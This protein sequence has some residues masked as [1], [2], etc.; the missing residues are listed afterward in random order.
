[1]FHDVVVE[2]AP[3]VEDFAAALDAL[4]AGLAGI[5]EDTGLVHA[6][7][8]AEAGDGAEL[9]IL[10]VEVAAEDV[11]VVL[12]DE[13]LASLMF[14]GNL[15]LADGVIDVL[16][17]DVVFVH[18]FLDGVPVLG[19]GLAGVEAF[20]QFLR[21]EVDAAVEVIDREAFLLGAFAD[22]VGS[23]AEDAGC[24]FRGDVFLLL[25]QG[26]GVAGVQRGEAVERISEFPDVDAD[27]PG[28]ELDGVDGTFLDALVD[29]GAR[30]VEEGRS[31]R[32]GEVVLGEEDVPRAVLDYGGFV[33][34][35]SRGTMTLMKVVVAEVGAEM[36]CGVGRLEWLPAV[37]TDIRAPFHCTFLNF[38]CG[39]GP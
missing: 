39:W 9:D 25:G 13:Q 29:G 23:E 18:D 34:R 4:H 33:R 19:T 32:D 3:D 30:D 12:G 28:A 7:F 14:L 15:L 27:G 20:L 22:M 35:P 24:V 10:L 36:R 31:V 8:L 21:V 6:Q 17:G 16:A 2:L 5:I 11:P 38:G 1:M 37:V 26:I